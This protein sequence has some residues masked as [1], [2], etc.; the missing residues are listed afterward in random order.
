MNAMKEKLQRLREQSAAMLDCAEQGEWEQLIECEQKRRTT[1]EA[2]FANTIDEKL[3]QQVSN[4]ISHI[5]AQDK[6]ILDSV[7]SHRDT[8]STAMKKLRTSRK[9]DAAYVSNAT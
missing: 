3:A 1:I 9:A 6:R 5:L 2:I 7:S 4:E 8:L